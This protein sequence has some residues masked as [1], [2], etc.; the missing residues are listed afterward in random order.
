MES[1]V[2]ATESI[3]H[4]GVPTLRELA[5]QTAEAQ[6]LELE[7]ASSASAANAWQRLVP[8]VK[9][10]VAAMQD[11]WV[12]TMYMIDNAMATGTGQMAALALFGVALDLMMCP[13][14]MFAFQFAFGEALYQGILDIL[15]PKIE[16]NVVGTESHIWSIR[17]QSLTVSLV[18]MLYFNVVMGIIVDAIVSKM[19][20]LKEGRGSI[21]E[22]NHTL[23]L[24]WCNL[25][26]TFIKEVCKANASE[27]GGVV[28]VLSTR[29][30]VELEKELHQMIHEDEWQG[31]R[32]I[33]CFGNAL[34]TTELL[35]VS[36]HL[37]RSITIMPSD[38][39]ADVS[40]ANL[41]RTL[42]SI[43]SLPELKGH[44]VADVGDVDNNSLLKVVGGNILETV[45]AKSIIGRLVVMGSRSAQLTKVYNAVLGFD[46]SEFYLSEWP[47]CVGL[48][49]NDVAER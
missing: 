43:Q 5:N 35:R 48:A 36:A 17:I 29:N 23:M 41:M 15:D 25:S 27:G 28:V 44:V 4:D 26:F 24:G 34:L 11:A 33:C 39:R 18:G 49:F 22:D 8:M 1:L 2:D 38:E 37:A 13:Y 12:W 40:D 14:E 9:T 19:E 42:L 30:K 7:Q 3:V 31:T 20:E 21:L 47:E 45:D 46:G 32:V 16:D 10:T 6:L